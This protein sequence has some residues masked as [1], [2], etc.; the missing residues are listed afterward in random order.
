M[1][2]ITTEELLSFDWEEARRN[3][4]LCGPRYIELHR[5][6]D[7]MEESKEFSKLSSLISRQETNIETCKTLMLEMEQKGMDISVGAMNGALS[8]YTK[9]MKRSLAEQF[10]NEFEARNIEPNHKTY[11]LLVEMFIRANQLEK[12]LEAKS[13]MVNTIGADEEVYGLLVRHLAD[14]N[15]IQDSLALLDDAMSH[16]ITIRERHKRELR[17]LLEKDGIALHPLI[18]ADPQK[19]RKDAAIARRS[20]KKRDTKKPYKL[21]NMMVGH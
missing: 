21:R 18:G 6:I 12:A 2:W 4:P 10:M 14:K 3:A 17:R 1:P 11:C 16:N 13:K 20:T 19:W 5:L 9:G 8:V 15:L 7:H